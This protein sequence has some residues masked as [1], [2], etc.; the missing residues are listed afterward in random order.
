MADYYVIPTNIGEAKMANALALGIP[1]AITELALGDGEGEGARGTPIPNPEA[2]ALVSERRR[3]PLN[4]FSVDPENPNVLIAEQVIPETAGGWWIREM[5]LFDE[6]G[7]LIFVCNTP[8]TYKP[9]LAEGSGR[10]QVVRMAS[11][12]SD[13]ASVTLKVDPSVVLATREYVQDVMEVHEEEFQGKIDALL[14]YLP[15]VDELRTTK[16]IDG[17]H[18]NVTGASDG[19][20]LLKVYWDPSSTAQDDGVNVFQ[21]SGVATGRWINLDKTVRML[22]ATGNDDQVAPVLKANKE[23]TY[24]IPEDTIEDVSLPNRWEPHI[25]GETG[26]LDLRGGQ[27]KHI[28]S[29]NNIGLDFG[30]KLSKDCKLVITGD[31]LSFNQYDYGGVSGVDGQKQPGVVTNWANLVRDTMLLNQPGFIP[32]SDLFLRSSAGG[33]TVAESDV[34]RVGNNSGGATYSQG[35]RSVNKLSATMADAEVLIFDFVPRYYGVGGKAQGLVMYYHDEKNGVG[36]SYNIEAFTDAGLSI[37]T[38]TI[39]TTGSNNG[40]HLRSVEITADVGG[41]NF[42][43]ALRVEITKVSGDGD[44]NIVG[45]SPQNFEFENTGVG[46]TTSQWLVDN[47][48]SILIDESPDIAIVVIGANDKGSDFSPATTYA[49]VK[50]TVEDLRSAKQDVQIVLIGP[51]PRNNALAGDDYQDPTGAADHHMYRVAL[52]RVA[53]NLNCGYLDTVSVFFNEDP[54]YYH[55]DNIH[56]SRDGNQVLF[57][58]LRSRF[59]PSLPGNRARQGNISNNTSIRPVYDEL[60]Q[61]V[62]PVEFDIRNR[63]DIVFDSATEEFTPSYSR[64]P[65]TLDVWPRNRIEPVFTVDTAVAGST[66]TEI[67]VNHPF[68]PKTNGF[69]VAEMNGTFVNTVSGSFVAVETGRS[70]TSITY[71]IFEVTANGFEN[72]LPSEL[73][74]NL[75]FTLRM[76]R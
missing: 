43:K 76:S 69:V 46:S 33:T 42:H 24:V 21:V 74:D 36:G 73:P 34:K 37:G 59:F 22:Q 63:V 4:S 57:E 52:Q 23:M 62:L 38:A 55:F 29:L 32:A 25:I 61:S 14:I 28:S 71:Q 9:Q 65:A 67:T 72:I 8:P 60:K 45:V 56:Y 66:G 6:D 49:N 50:Q 68:Y 1:L 7:D 17:Q 10:T 19:R 35:A 40:Q 53:S 64:F 16:G 75:R 26:A 47:R 20:G 5:G 51:P 2:T 18:A 39:D 15:T 58:A 44:L 30:S 54:D 3:A 41:S 31:S 11:V 12:V 48:Q 27:L 13:T 70:T